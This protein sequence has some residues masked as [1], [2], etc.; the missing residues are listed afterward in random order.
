[1]FNVDTSFSLVVQFAVGS[2]LL[3]SGSAGGITVTGTVDIGAATATG[4][5]T[6]SFG[7]FGFSLDYNQMECTPIGTT[8]A[9]TTITATPTTKTTASPQ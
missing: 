4:S 7:S 6:N 5:I 8:P 2:P 9:P 3:I 1:M